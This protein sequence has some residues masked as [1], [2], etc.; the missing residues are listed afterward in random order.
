MANPTLQDL[1][2]RNQADLINE[3][4]GLDPTLPNSFEGAL[5]KMIAGRAF[6]FYGS[7]TLLVA[8]LLLTTTSDNFLDAYASIFKLVRNPA[9]A[10]AGNIAITGTDGTLIPSGTL[11]NSDSGISYET[12]S[13]AN[14]SIFSD[15]AASF[16][17]N[18]IVVTVTTSAP[19]NFGT[20]MSVTI[21]PAGVPPEIIGTYQIVVTADNQFTYTTATAATNGV[22]AP[23]IVT[24]NFVSVVV[25]AT[26]FGQNT[27]QSSGVQ[28]T[29][30]SPISGVDT[31]AYVNFNGLTGGAD[32]ESDEAFRERTQYR[33]RNPIAYFS[34]S[35]LKNLLFSFGGITRVW[36][37]KLNPANGFTV[38]YVR[39]ENDPIFPSPADTN[40]VRSKIPTGAEIP[41]ANVV[42]ASPVE[43]SIEFTFGNL[44]PDTFSMRNAVTAALEQFFRDSVTMGFEQNILTQIEYVRPIYAAIDVETG[45]PVSSFTLTT[46][47]GVAPGDINI[48][49]DELPTLG[50]V[51]YP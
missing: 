39:D 27:N 17:V 43:K 50:V 20:G 2:D 37:E 4:E 36:V 49:N 23:G 21:D 28:L 44:Q 12:T 8:R 7:L 22:Y 1:I 48:A 45:E 11:F 26:I 15:N 51:T 34:P 14:I 31:T 9:T 16:S 41:D 40:E 46:V 18:G 30:S 47:N 3:F 13:N 5:S 25:Q 29:L 6:E 42:V 24:A 35:M 19:H 33:I 32:V 10:S 38:Y